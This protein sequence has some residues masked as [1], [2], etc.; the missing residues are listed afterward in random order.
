MI[1]SAQQER[2]KDVLQNNLNCFKIKAGQK[3]DNIRA[4]IY[5]SPSSRRA[6]LYFLTILLH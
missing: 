5:H 6:V 3:S 4:L 1:I 2:K